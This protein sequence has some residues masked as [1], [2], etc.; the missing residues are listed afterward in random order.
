MNWAGGTQN[1]VYSN[2]AGWASMAFLPCLVIGM[3][4]RASLYLVSHSQE[5]F[6]TWKS[7]SFKKIR[8]KTHGLLLPKHRSTTTS[9]Q[10]PFFFFF[11]LPWVF[12]VARGLS[13]VVVSGGYSFVVVRGFLTVV[14]SLVA[15][16]GL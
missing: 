2:W 6:F 14:A 10:P 3:G 4:Y 12:V 5:A 8:T 1:L 15:E 7:R 9:F 11:W 13:L 16:L